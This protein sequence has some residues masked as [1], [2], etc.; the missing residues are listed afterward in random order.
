MIV[1]ILKGRSAV[2]DEDKVC[3]RGRYKGNFPD[4][5][6]RNAGVI[7]DFLSGKRF[8]RFFQQKK[9]A[10]IVQNDELLIGRS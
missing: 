10:L 5:L 9:T 2:T 4:K 8:F 3:F 6:K 1:I 7:S